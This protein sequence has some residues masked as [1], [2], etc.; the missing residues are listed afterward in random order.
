M[1]EQREVARS[2]PITAWYGSGRW[3][4]RKADAYFAIARALV[5]L[6][7]PRWLQDEDNEQPATCDCHEGQT[8]G[9]C[10]ASC[11]LTPLANWRLRRDKMRALFWRQFREVEY[12]GTYDSFDGDR[13][14]RFIR[15]VARHLMHV[16]ATRAS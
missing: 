16:D 5:V 2:K 6:K 9:D 7:Y 14:K 11:E 8:Q 12:D 1:S 10:R 15:R 4:H 13:W 3:F